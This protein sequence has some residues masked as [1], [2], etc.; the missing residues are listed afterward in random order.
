MAMSGMHERQ[1]TGEEEEIVDC[2]WRA[3]DSLRRARRDLSTRGAAPER[4]GLGRI[5]AIATRRK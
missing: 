2:R 5:I 4:R 3:R 1:E